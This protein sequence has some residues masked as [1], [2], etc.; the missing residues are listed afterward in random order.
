MF[1]ST[2]CPPNVKRWNQ[3]IPQ[4]FSNTYPLKSENIFS[5]PSEDSFPLPQ[6]FDIKS[7]PTVLFFGR[8]KDDWPEPFKQFGDDETTLVE[9]A[10]TQWEIQGPVPKVLLPSVLLPPP[11]PRRFLLESN[12]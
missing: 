4:Y 11:L 8:D 5:C 3:D 7:Y 10:T 9:F 12:I 6:E 1:R 2:L